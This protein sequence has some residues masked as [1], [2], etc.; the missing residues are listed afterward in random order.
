MSACTPLPEALVETLLWGI[1]FMCDKTLPTIRSSLEQHKRKVDSYMISRI[2]PANA[3]KVSAFMFEPLN[4]KADYLVVMTM[5]PV[6]RKRMADL[7]LK[8]KKLHSHASQYL[9]HGRS[10]VIIKR[11]TGLEIEFLDSK[12]HV[13][14]LDARTYSDI[15]KPPTETYYRPTFIGLIRHANLDR[16]SIDLM[17]EQCREWRVFSR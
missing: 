2:G 13:L 10:F 1:R 9:K 3:R 4:K 12:G 11:I 15:M 16:R 7:F 6:T 17:I 5:D 14:P 8:F